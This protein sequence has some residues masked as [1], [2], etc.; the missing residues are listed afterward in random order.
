MITGRP[1]FDDVDTIDALLLAQQHR[2]LDF[3]FPI[4]IPP[5]IERILRRAVAK[6]PE[7]R[8][9]SVLAF[10]QALHGVTF[11]ERVSQPPSDRVDE[12]EPRSS[13]AALAATTTNARR[14]TALG[15]YAR[16]RPALLIAAVFVGAALLTVWVTIIVRW[17]GAR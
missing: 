17:L 9:D 6:D 10:I 7:D 2:E 3:E 11:A 15:R 5:A 16:R 8:F 1:P 13:G 4:P 12:A 14:T